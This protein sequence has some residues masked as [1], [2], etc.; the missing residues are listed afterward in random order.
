VKIITRTLILLAAALVVV[1]IT[2]ALQS[3]GLLASVGAPGGFEGRP[4]GGSFEGGPPPG[5]FTPGGEGMRHE[6][7][8]D[9]GGFG[10]RHEGGRGGMF[11]ASEIV[12]NLGVTAVIIAVFVLL[13]RAFNAFRP[14]RR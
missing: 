9:R 1:G 11:N 6:G 4:S 14:Q 10:D 5:G 12:K 2:M 13:S 3:A 7:F 8:G